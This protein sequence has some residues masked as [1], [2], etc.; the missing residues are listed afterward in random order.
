MK[1]QENDNWQHFERKFPTQPKSLSVFNY[2]E[3]TKKAKCYLHK[4]KIEVISQLRVENYHD[5]LNAF[6][7]K[8]YNKG[9][10]KTV[11]VN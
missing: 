4:F 11:L 2:P 5:K 7:M 6:A 9:S 1:E 10:L 8:W 3:R